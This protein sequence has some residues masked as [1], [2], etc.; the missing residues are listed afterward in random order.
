MGSTKRAFALKP[1]NYLSVL[2]LPGLVPS[3][4]ALFL[5]RCGLQTSNI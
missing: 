2:T 3:I 4:T 5:A 1:A